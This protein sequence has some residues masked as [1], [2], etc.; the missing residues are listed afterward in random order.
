MVTPFEEIRNRV[1]GFVFGLPLAIAGWALLGW[2]GIAWL[3]PDW[4][5]AVASF[6]LGTLDPSTIGKH[7]A[8]IRQWM[9]PGGLAFIAMLSAIMLAIGT[10]GVSRGLGPA[11]IQLSDEY[12][13]V[14]GPV[15]GLVRL[16]KRVKPGTRF[17]LELRCSRF[18]PRESG[19]ASNFDREEIEYTQKRTF[20]AQDDEKG[21]YFPFTIEVPASAPASDSLFKWRARITKDAWI[22]G[23]TEYPVTLG[24]ATAGQI[25]ALREAESPELGAELDEINQ[26]VTR[27]GGRMMPHHRAQW[28]AKTPEEREKALKMLEAYEKAWSKPGM[29]QGKLVGYLVLA[30]VLGIIGTWILR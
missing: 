14:G 5:Q 23:V 25:H 24:A 30:C 16:P 6:A 27:A 3:N 15:E 2:V 1:Y 10:S 11:R 17:H 9:E 21:S 12:T 7:G 22:S 28:A 26:T 8:G 18:F 19:D 29:T 13:R 4:A 20:E